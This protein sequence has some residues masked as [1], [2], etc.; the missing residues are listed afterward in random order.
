MK[1]AEW[2]ITLSWVKAHAGMEGNEL[3]DR[4]SKRAATKGT[5]PDSYTRIPKSV[6]LRQLKEGNAKKWQTSWAQTTKGSTTKEYFPDIEGRQKMKLYHTGNLTTILTG[7]GNIKR[8]CIDSTSARIQ[9]A[10]VEKGNKQ[11]ST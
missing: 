10:L 9:C 5:I 11:K 6:V 7:H 8:T 4:L 3:E 1:K 2:Q